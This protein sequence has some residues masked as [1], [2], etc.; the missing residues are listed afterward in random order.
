MTTVGTDKMTDAEY[1]AWYYEEERKYH[2]WSRHYKIEFL[3]INMDLVQQG[4][5]LEI[6]TQ[7]QL[8][9]MFYNG[10]FTLNEFNRQFIG[11]KPDVPKDQNATHEFDDYSDVI[12]LLEL[13]QEYGRQKSEQYSVQGDRFKSNRVHECLGNISACLRILGIEPQKEP[14]KQRIILM[15]KHAQV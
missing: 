5:D 14:V 7:D 13:I 2:E 15:H 9:S 1:W 6:I 3:K 10:S 4:L 12:E 8:L 11:D